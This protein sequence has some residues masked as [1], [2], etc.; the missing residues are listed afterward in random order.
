[1]SKLS[2]IFVYLLS[3]CLFNTAYASIQC[4]TS[5]CYIDVYK[6]VEPSTLPQ[7]HRVNQI[8]AKLTQTIGSQ[9]AILS[10]LVVINSNG[11]PWAAALSDN[12]IIITKGAIQSM[13][14]GVSETLGD[15]RIAFV[16]GHELSHLVTDDLF[17]HKAFVIN[18]SPNTKQSYLRARPEEEY[19]AD[20]RGY[21]V[22]SIA[23]YRTD[24]LIGGNHDF[25]QNWLS[26]ITPTT[27][28]NTHPNNESRRQ[29]IQTGFKNILDQIPYY[30][31]AVVL[32]H[33]GHY[34]DAQ[35]LLED[36]LNLVE[37]EQAYSNLG[38]VHI[39]LARK[40][41]PLDMA[42]KYWIPTL[43][44]QSTSLAKRKKRSL[45]DTELPTEALEHLNRA[46]TMLL[47][48]ISMNSD[49]LTSYINLAAVYLYMPNKVHK[50]Y[51]AIEDA[52]LTT[53]GSVPDVRKQLESIY[54]LI[55]VQDK[56]DGGDRWPKARDTLTAF[57][58][59]PNPA[60]N[61]L[62]NLGRM[63]DARGRDDTA[64]R[65]WQMLHTRLSSLPPAYQEQIC[66]RLQR[67]CPI[68]DHDS[69]WFDDDLPLGKD[70]RYPEVTRYLSKNWNGPVTPAKILPNLKAQ[71]FST[72]ESNQLLALDNHLEMII[73]R[74]IPKHYADIPSLNNLYG[75]P[76]V[77]LPMRDG[78]LLS[79]RSGW[80]AFVN[81]KKEVSE[82][83]ITKLD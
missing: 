68:E 41:M 52:R 19:R 62:Y 69:P 66:F 28:T 44:E 74:D 42:Y 75:E 71:V 13:Y 14:E 43:L 18:N 1:M 48:A 33:F 70:I 47:K 8:H 15:A 3:L 16:I 10:K 57:A 45:F 39:Q 29:F 63:L 82:L 55:R 36:N 9:R 6:S 65:Y 60:P 30:H 32:A 54:Q 40:L 83:W 20:L 49:N 11:H 79:Y 73:V 53:L 37:T 4:A 59:A 25:F 22:A 56:I 24:L 26:Q 81:S 27:N 64:T 51:A 35:Y 72:N 46:E 5:K 67:D 50:A 23:G 78:H 76:Y 77:Y 2:F 34:T 7:I 21:T 38:Y 12:S 58:E 31:F 17:H 61:L 80:A